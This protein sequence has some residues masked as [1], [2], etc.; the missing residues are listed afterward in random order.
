MISTPISDFVE[1]YAKSDITRLHM[2][3][4]KGVGNIEAYDITEVLGADS[5]FDPDGIIRESEENVSRLFGAPTYYSTEGSSL[6]IRAM[7]YLAAIDARLKGKEPKV[8]AGR[9]AHRVF[10]SAAALLDLEVEWL[11]G[12]GG[13]LSCGVTA[14][15]VDNALSG[16]STLTAVYLTSPDYLGNTVDI[17]AIS[18]VC[19]RHGALLLIDNAH[20]AY[21]KFLTPSRHPIDLG[22]DMCADSA[23][24]T[25]SV[26]TGGAYLHLSDS[27]S[28]KVSVMAKDALALFAS[29]SPSYLILASLDRMNEYLDGDYRRDLTTLVDKI[30][31]VK[32]KLAENG[33]TLIGD[34]PMKITI[35]ASLYGYR[36]DAL[37]NLLRA[38]GIEPEFSDRDYVTLMP[39]VSDTGA[40]EKLLDVLLEIPGKAPIQDNSL[41]VLSPERVMSIREAT[42]MPY[43]SVPLSECAGRILAV[44]DAS[45]PP[46]VPILFPGERITEEHISVF[47]YYGKTALKVIKEKI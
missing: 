25:L 11:T 12:D 38:S 8:L 4:H 5:L 47:G 14:G 20:G 42:M 7:I 34:E 1:K 22:A 15:D 21:L 43:E 17:K 6:A 29:T 26:L 40:V 3:G 33:Y 13:Y 31:V 19:K 35:D 2:P 27:I 45:C 16:D 46:A 36:G 18:E 41:R 28:L 32:Q 9:N 44:A 39:S 24:K 30:K 10:V 37:A 23:H